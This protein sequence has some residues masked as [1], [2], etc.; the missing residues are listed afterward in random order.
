V[1]GG[2]IVAL[3]AG[4]TGAWAV[5]RPAGSAAAT[6][7]VVIAAT[8]GT[9]RQT[10]AASGTI[11]PAKKADLSFTVPGTV[12]TVAAEVGA[13][14]AQGAEL[15]QVGDTDLRAAVTSAQASVDA[16]S[17]Q[18]TAQQDASASAT[19]IAS[20]SAQ[21]TAAKSRL[22]S[23]QQS[24]SDATLTA[25]FAG[26]VAAVTIAA[27][28]RVGSSGSAGTGQQASS[29]TTSSTA[30]ITVIS[31]S[32]WIVDASV[33][34]ADLAQIKKG[35]QAE[36]TPT[37]GAAKVFGT[38]RSAGI[39]A[40]S[41]SSGSATFPVTIAITGSPSGLYAGGTASVSIIVKQV[42]DVLT[43]PT[44]AVRTS[45]GKTVVKVRKGGKDTDVPV[46]VGTVYGASTEIKS[47]IAEGDQIVLDAFR[48]GG[49]AGRTGQTGRTGRTGGGFG[50][51]GGFGP[52]GGNGQ[53]PTGAGG[54]P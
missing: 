3:A 46:T 1:A 42:A 26:T 39:V 19:Q 30:A 44:L 16:A 32:S 48:P 40:S 31:T 52:G 23:A 22:A 47:G 12:T 33:G 17:A 41:S 9:I 21:L 29:G 38:V 53:A 11:A 15:A 24:L 8:R 43:V 54:T 14:V 49:G 10:V 20:A 50:Q 7:S 13:K 5:T 28:D 35:L 25:P 18:L 27:G 4:G 34:S 45:G 51:N 6:T 2:V 37:G 36:I